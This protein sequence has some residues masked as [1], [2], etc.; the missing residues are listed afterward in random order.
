MRCHIA[1]WKSPAGATREELSLALWPGRPVE[2]TA[3]VFHVTL[4]RLRRALQPEGSQECEWSYIQHD[5]LMW[6]MQ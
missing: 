2:E 3:N 1:L 6:D 4:Y 5:P